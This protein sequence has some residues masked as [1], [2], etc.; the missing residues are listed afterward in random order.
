MAVEHWDSDQ[1]GP[2]SEAALRRKLEARGYQVTRYVYPPGTIFP[3]HSHG[4]D[5][6]DAVVSGQFQMSMQGKSVVLDAGDC[7]A[8]PR[9][10]IHSAEV[11][12]DQQLV[13]PTRS[14]SI[15][16]KSEMR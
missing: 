1:D 16:V 14:E 2:L 10:E 9:G 13:S 6:I 8:V 3:A 11:V 12:G 5:K 7:L 15:R 4:V